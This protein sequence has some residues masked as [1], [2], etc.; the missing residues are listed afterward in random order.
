M[1]W[2]IGCKGMLGKEIVDIFNIN[3]I[4]HYAT[5]TEVDITDLDSITAF[6]K[7]KNI[8]YI[9]NCAAYTNVEEAEEQ[10]E[11]AYRINAT[12]PANLAVFSKDRDIVLIHFSTDYV[13]DDD[14]KRPL[15]ETDKLNPKSV[16]GQT[17]LE[18]EKKVQEKC[19]KYFIFRI[20]WLYG[21][22]G[23]NFIKKIQEQ[24]K[25]KNTVKVISDQVGT[26]TWTYNVAE[27]VLE[28]ITKKNNKYGIYNF[29]GMG[30]TNWYLYAKYI[31]RLLKKN[32]HIN[33]KIELI[34]CKSTEFKTKAVRPYY[35]VLLKDKIR[36]NFRI[37]IGHWKKSLRKYFQN[38]GNI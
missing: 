32:N 31:Y 14:I 20:S 37:K 12:G 1:I 16:Y 36:N 7:D 27:L 15:K 8:D 17:K 29:S 25:I 13:Y 35:S 11:L 10:L 6:A 23:N 5:D 38:I 28:T 9:V 19:V 30:K 18:G 3:Q 34:P 24:F 26:P 2:L 21:K 4:S 22:H 33:M